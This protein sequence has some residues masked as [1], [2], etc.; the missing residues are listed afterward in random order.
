MVQTKGLVRER[1]DF[2]ALNYKQEKKDALFFPLGQPV[3]CKFH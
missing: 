3:L 1:C 2:T